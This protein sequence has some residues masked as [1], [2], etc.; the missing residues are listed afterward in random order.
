MSMGCKL[1]EIIED[2]GQEIYTCH[3]GST[4]VTREFD[5]RRWNYDTIATFNAKKNTVWAIGNYTGS[6]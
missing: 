2:D 3:D 6:R 1:D 5:F 4:T